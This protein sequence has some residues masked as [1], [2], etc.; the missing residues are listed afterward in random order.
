MYRNDLSEYKKEEFQPCDRETIL[1]RIDENMEVDI[2]EDEVPETF[3]DVTEADAALMQKRLQGKVRELSE[4]VLST[5]LMRQRSMEDAVARYARVIIRFQSASGDVVQALFMVRETVNALY[6]YVKEILM[7]E[8]LDFELY[9]SPPKSVL[10]DKAKTL[11]EADLVPMSIVYI[12][13]AS[14]TANV[15]KERVVRDGRA[16]MMVA[17]EVVYKWLSLKSPLSRESTKESDLKRKNNNQETNK[18]NDS[19]EVPKWLKKGKK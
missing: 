6:K 4:Q 10:D 14:D 3:Y 1:Y 8:S 16:T 19:K 15:W 13:T 12:S 5:D 7:N 2:K 9:T 11:I 18:D 17:E